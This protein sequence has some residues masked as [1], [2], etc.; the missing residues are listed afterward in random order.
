MGLRLPCFA[1]AI[2]EFALAR[3]AGAAISKVTGLA[4]K[5]EDKQHVTEALSTMH[6]HMPHMTSLI[7]RGLSLRCADLIN[8]G[9]I[10]TLQHL[11][12]ICTYGEHYQN[13]QQAERLD[14]FDTTKDYLLA[15]EEHLSP[16]AGL[17]NLVSLHIEEEI[18][19]VLP[20]HLQPI[21]LL[22][23]LTHLAL[24]CAA[25]EEQ[26]QHIVQSMTE[27]IYQAF[28]SMQRL[29]SLQVDIGSPH[30]TLLKGLKVLSLTKSEADWEFPF[31]FTTLT[32]LSELSLSGE[33]RRWSYVLVPLSSV[34][35][36]PYIRKA[37]FHFEADPLVWGF[38]GDLVTLEDLTLQHCNLSNEAFEAVGQLTQLTS[39]DFTMSRT[40]YGVVDTE[41]LHA[42]GKLVQLSKLHG[43]FVSRTRHLNEYQLADW[44]DIFSESPA[45]LSIQDVQLKLHRV[46]KDSDWSSDLDGD[47]S[48]ASDDDRECEHC[49]EDLSLSFQLDVEDEE[50]DSDPLQDS[51]TAAEQLDAWA[52]GDAPSGAYLDDSAYYT[53]DEA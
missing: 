50:T 18:P 5:M 34:Q 29:A 42:L 40:F 44:Y 28:G 51:E 27:S 6:K 43:K 30:M 4:P 31:G 49:M 13:D 45:F 53:A 38:L 3:C 17:S 48:C 20:Q 39:L 32:S 8:I 1:F 9:R 52:A 15:A 36:L 21:S 23:Q 37:T 14:H 47:V 16:F 24:H 12:Y 25:R 2:L 7:V 35:F 10:L 19:N 41:A 26:T 46:P 33:M 22:T 11:M